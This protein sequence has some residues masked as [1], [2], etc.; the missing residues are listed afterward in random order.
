M[1]TLID[2]L[3]AAVGFVLIVAFA[4]MLIL[5]VWAWTL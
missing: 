3:G 4:W 2:T 1:K 5:S